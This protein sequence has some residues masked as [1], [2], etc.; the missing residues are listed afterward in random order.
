MI[1]KKLVLYIAVI[2][3]IF[4]TTACHSVRSAMVNERLSELN[5][6]ND[7]EIA[8]ARC[9]SIIEALENKDKEELRK[10]FS[11]SAQEEAKD[12]DSAIDY[13]LELY[14]GKLK[15]KDGAVVTSESTDQGEKEKELG[16]SYKVV[17]DEGNYSIYF[18]DKLVDTKN[19]DNVGLYTLEIIKESADDEFYYWGSGTDRAGIILP[20]GK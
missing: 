16:C 12:M 10:M 6:S 9:Q 18:I 8:D 4:G 15:S 20:D 3:I 13:L 17:T 7:D 14:Q 19:S 2:S 5:S 1:V 11:P